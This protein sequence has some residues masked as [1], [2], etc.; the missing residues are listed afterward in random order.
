[1]MVDDFGILD[2]PSSRV[3][4]SA[5]MTPEARTALIEQLLAMIQQLQKQL[6][7]MKAKL[8]A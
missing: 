8:Q 3:L 7:D 5:T 1:M 6:E 4:R 2:L